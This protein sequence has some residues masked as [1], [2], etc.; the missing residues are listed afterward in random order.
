M[1]PDHDRQRTFG[2]RAFLLGGGQFV[3][4]SALVGRMYYLQV[5]ESERYT[6]LA[7]VNRIYVH[8]LAPPRG[9]IFDRYGRPLA[10]NL[11]DYRV[12]I[13][14]ELVKDVNATLDALSTVIDLTKSDRRRIRREIRKKSRFVPVTVREDLEWSQVSRI[15]VNAPDLPGISIQTGLSRYYPH[16]TATAHTVGYVGPVAE[17]EIGGDPLLQLP[18]FR[19]GKN[20]IEYF[21]DRVLRGAGGTSQVEINA[22]GRIIRELSR[23]EGKPGTDLTLTLD[24]E[25]QKFAGRRFGS[26]SGAAVVLDV[27]TGQVMAMVSAPSFDPNHFEKG[28]SG[29]EW[30]KLIGNSRKPLNDKAITGQYAP[31]STF[32]VAVALAAL[33]AKV[34]TPAHEVTCVGHVNLGNYRFHCWR[35]G[36]HGRLSLMPAI[37]QS[38]DVYFYDLAR[39]VGIDRIAAMSR[40][41]GFGTPVGVDLRGERPGLVP[42]RAWKKRLRGEPWQQGET[43]I[44]GIGQGYLLATPLQLAVL[45]AR[46]VNGGRAVVPRVRMAAEGDAI[47]PF[48]KLDIAPAA[49]AI[50]RAG[51]DGVVNDPTGTAYRSRIVDKKFAMG[52][53]TGTSQV[54]RITMKER[55]EGVRKNSELPWELRDHALFIGYAPVAEPRYAV[56]VV[57]EHGGGGSKAAAPIARDILLQAQRRHAAQVAPR[58]SAGTVGREG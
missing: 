52:G 1:H 16:G 46:I 55:E 23:Q 27:H 54:R 58:K 12:T 8:L 39:R 33:D 7:E 3:L 20:G 6:M 4:L 48:A 36:G 5:M 34:I 26:E 28:I 49:L 37:R 57:V 22:H 40:K 18:G 29:K 14:A 32:K 45:T 9:L 19:I 17:S 13:I 15:E 21:Y 30:R 44:A 35:R 43:L 24:I 42:T 2:R 41:L 47:K 25:L 53:K 31:G 56:A 50:V 10:E 38:C 51:M 11:Q